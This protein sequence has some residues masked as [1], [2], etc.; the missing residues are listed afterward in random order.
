MCIR[1]RLHTGR[2]H[3]IRAH[4]A[5]IGHPLVGDA[6]YGGSGGQPH[7][8]LCA[9]MLRFCFQTDAGALSYLDGREFSLDD[10][11]FTNNFK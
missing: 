11:W 3:Q 2:S 10:V 4:M 6:K 8:L 1:D 7:Q 5:H 9:Y